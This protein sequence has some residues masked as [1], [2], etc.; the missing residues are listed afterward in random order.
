MFSPVLIRYAE[1]LMLSRML[2]AWRVGRERY[3]R[4]INDHDNGQVHGQRRSGE[5]K[6]EDGDD[7]GGGGG[8]GNSG[9]VMHHFHHLCPATMV[10]WDHLATNMG[11]IF[12]TT[13]VSVREARGLSRGGGRRGGAWGEVG[14]TVEEKGAED[15]TGEGGEGTVD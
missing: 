1:P 6:D 10:W 14:R 5:N 8:G 4:R 13:A 7:G 11:R 15:E 9:G 12:H 3:I 2:K